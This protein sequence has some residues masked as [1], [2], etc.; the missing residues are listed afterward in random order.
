[1]PLLWSV[2]WSW[3]IP[4]V[5]SIQLNNE[6]TSVCFHMVLLKYSKQSQNNAQNNAQTEVCQ[7]QPTDPLPYTHT[8][9]MMKSP[10]HFFPYPIR[11][12]N[13]EKHEPEHTI[14]HRICSCFVFPGFLCLK[15]FE[16]YE[17]R[18]L[19]NSFQPTMNPSQ[20]TSTKAQYSSKFSVRFNKSFKIRAVACRRWQLH[21]SLCDSGCL[22][23]ESWKSSGDRRPNPRKKGM[24]FCG[25]QLWSCLYVS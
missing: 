6:Y 12:V 24:H 16:H 17:Q 2:S 11:I 5:F 22:D 3:Q 4:Q 18:P 15:L 8:V 21:V 7:H 19:I 1:M 25:S 14:I 9:I 10:T 23:A 20:R 13:L